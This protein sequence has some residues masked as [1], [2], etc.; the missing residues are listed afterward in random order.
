MNKDLAETF[1]SAISQKV[2]K[3]KEW[4]AYRVILDML[5]SD[6]NYIP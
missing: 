2:Q 6:N 1:C 4:H 3:Q 5:F